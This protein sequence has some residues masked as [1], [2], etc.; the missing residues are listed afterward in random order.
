M[1]TS[2]PASRSLAAICRPIRPAPIQPILGCSSA[3]YAIT[4][5][6]LHSPTAVITAPAPNH[7]AEI[8]TIVCILVAHHP[9]ELLSGPVRGDLPVERSQ[10]RAAVVALFQQQQLGGTG[11]LFHQPLRV[12][13]GDQPVELAH[14]RQQ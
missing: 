1:A 5:S 8:I 6:L 7:S 4:M 11:R 10:V 12:L 13:P 3:R 9:A 14:D 2:C